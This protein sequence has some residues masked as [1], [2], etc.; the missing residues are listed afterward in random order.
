MVEDQRQFYNI[1]KITFSDHNTLDR[2]YLW[3]IWLGKYG[4]FN[5]LPNLFIS[6]SQ[7]IVSKS[8]GI[9]MIVILS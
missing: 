1:S 8:N 7:T 9:Y 3:R 2:T 6:K 4:I 5:I